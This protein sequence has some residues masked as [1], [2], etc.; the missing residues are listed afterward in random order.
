MEITLTA[1]EEELIQAQLALV[2]QRK[3]LRPRKVKHFI[4]SEKKK[5]FY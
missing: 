5:G 4:T 3:L 2:K 1:T